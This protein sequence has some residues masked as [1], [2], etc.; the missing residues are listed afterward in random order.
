M[1]ARHRCIARFYLPKNG[2]V[3]RNNEKM[4]KDKIIFNFMGEKK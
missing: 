4:T 2:E 1:I 3:Q